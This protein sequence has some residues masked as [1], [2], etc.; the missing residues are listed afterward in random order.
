MNF[1]KYDAFISYS[2]SIDPDTARM[3]QNGLRKL[4]KPWYKLETLKV[5]RDSTNLTA[6]PGLW[7]DI[8]KALRQSEYLIL[9]ASP[10]AASSK[11]VSKEI[12]FWLS[13]KSKEKLLIALVE[14]KIFWQ[15]ETNDF[16]WAQTNCLPLVLSG[17]I[18]EEPLF[19]DFTGAII[20]F[21]N[22]NFKFQLSKLSSKIQGITPD[23]LIGEDF[24][25][26]RKTQILKKFV[27]SLV[28]AFVI[29]IG[30]LTYTK[31]KSAHGNEIAIAGMI[32]EEFNPTKAYI[33]VLDG[34][35]I[36]GEDYLFQLACGIYNRNSTYRNNYQIDG[37]KLCAQGKNGLL[38]LSDNYDL[39]FVDSHRL[40]HK[41][42]YQ[43]SNRYEIEQIEI[44][45]NCEF[46]LLKYESIDS[47]YLYDIRGKLKRVFPAIWGRFSSQTGEL[48]LLSRTLHFFKFKEPFNSERPNYTIKLPFIDMQ[49]NI[50]C[51]SSE[52][53]SVLV[54]GHNGKF[55]VLNP[56]T[57]NIINSNLIICDNCEI[58]S[59]SANGQYIG[60]AEGMSII[61]TDVFGKII[62]KKIKNDNVKNI[63]FSSKSDNTFI[64]SCMDNA[65]YLDIV[66]SSGK[67]T[68]LKAHDSE[69][70]L[71]FSP[72]GYSFTT[73]DSQNIFTWDVI[74]VPLKVIDSSYMNWS[75]VK[76]AKNSEYIAAA[77]MD[78]N[79]KIWNIAGEEIF[80]HKIS[81]RFSKNRFVFVDEIC[82]LAFIGKNQNY[83]EVFDICR[84]KVLY[85]YEQPGSKIQCIAKYDGKGLVG[86]TES[87]F[88]VF[89][90][91]YGRIVNTVKVFDD[92]TSCLSISIK[93][94]V[95]LT[96]DD[97]GR[98]LLINSDGTIIDTLLLED[99]EVIAQTADMS[100]DGRFIIAAGNENKMYLY[101]REKKGY[102]NHNEVKTYMNYIMKATFI[103]NTDAI[104]TCG[105]D[106]TFKIWDS[107]GQVV[108][109]VNTGTSYIIWDFDVF[110]DG[111]TIV[112][113][114]EKSVSLWKIKHPLKKVNHNIS[115]NTKL[116]WK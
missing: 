23:E 7:P 25:Q 79:L 61:I 62:D 110:P 85:Q 64:S 33:Q 31:V 95:I 81:E 107:L 24:K 67:S 106:Q 90:N 59:I 94:D 12:E 75:S 66:G 104:L 74:G 13:N 93:K 100:S 1:V 96:A 46:I 101:E 76:V 26:H 91:F 17:R 42:K 103:N 86:I 27:L 18:N 80:S 20:D 68:L 4:A 92:E 37:L 3:I 105:S 83:I 52:N 49:S 14:G 40:T 56:L 35:R 48:K 108:S 28:S 44:S 102:E 38:L 88:I 32:K 70:K 111:T 89:W 77:D 82:I 63:L 109:S 47:I 6:S 58:K 22:D 39:L 57:N 113:A 115:M 16:D 21:S 65:V 36:S 8:E 19:A 2:H 55:K 114:D 99:G 29:V 5:F 30:Y 9:L 11:W 73:Y 69:S 45:P 116:E 54:I 72:D 60:M 41:I 43:N 71:C 84:G 50:T 78:G 112:T 10:G 87:G 15:H 53:D 97:Y 98:I 34:F 51:L